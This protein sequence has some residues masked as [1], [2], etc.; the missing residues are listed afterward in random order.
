MMEGYGV[1][2]TPSVLIEGRAAKEKSEADPREFIPVRVRMP[3]E[4]TPNGLLFYDIF[5]ASIADPF[6]VILCSFGLRTGNRDRA[7]PFA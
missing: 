1:G 3:P 7:G 6:R 4:T 5:I 2:E